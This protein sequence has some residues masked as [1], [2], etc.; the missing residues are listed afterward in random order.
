MK[1]LSLE[2]LVALNHISRD[3]TLLRMSSQT[4]MHCMS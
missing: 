4:H 3:H 2:N 1:I